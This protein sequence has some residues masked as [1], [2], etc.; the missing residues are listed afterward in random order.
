MTTISRYIDDPPSF[1]FWEIDE[2]IVFSF[3]LGIGILLDI[4]SFVILIAVAIT[5]ILKKVKRTKSEGFFM[6]ALY[7]YVGVP[8]R[9]CPP[10][11]MRLF[12]E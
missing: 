7:W 12:F 3:F 8:L 1:L 10:S 5:M 2:I 4:L 9:G 6:H 11:W